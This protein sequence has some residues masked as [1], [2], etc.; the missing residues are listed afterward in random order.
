MKNTNRVRRDDGASAPEPQT[1]RNP[2]KAAII[3]YDFEADNNISQQNLS[4]RE[5]AALERAS[6]KVGMTLKQFI[7]S[8]VAFAVQTTE[9]IRPTETLGT[10]QQP[11]KSDC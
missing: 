6:Q 5:F 1:K 11:G 2:P 4:R 9:E 10:K 8:A 7:K 3:L